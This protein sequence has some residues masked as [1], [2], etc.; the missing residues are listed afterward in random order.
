MTSSRPLI[1]GLVDDLMFGVRIEKTAA[2]LG[3]EYRAIGRA[4]ELGD[5][6]NDPADRVPGERLFGQAGALVDKLTRWQPALLIIDLGNASIPWR[7]WLPMLKSAAATRRLPVL[8]YG[9]HV[10]AA[11]LRQARQ[12]GADEVV[13]RSKMAAE[14]PEL[15]QRLAR[16]PDNTAVAAAC[17]EPLLDLAVAGLRAMNEGRYYDAHEFL[18]DAWNADEGPGRDL[19]RALLQIAVAFYQIQRGNYRGAQ[20][21]FL[22][23][24]QWFEPLPDL[25]RGVDIADLRQTV[26]AVEAELRARGADGLEHFDTALFK[27]VN[28]T[29]AGE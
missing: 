12:L 16:D 6:S 1:V 7:E 25:C 8:G 28:F 18:E 17:E 3:Y 23:A 20:K 21:M 27:P 22:R 2:A 14:L 24:R 15:I 29:H 4:V 19:Y 10:D 9:A 13:P 11:T 5:P 26:T